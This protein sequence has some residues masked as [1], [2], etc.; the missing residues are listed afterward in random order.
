L[1]RRYWAEFIGTFV[2]VFAPVFTSSV[3]KFHG[4]DGSLLVAAFVSG[5]SVTAMI[6]ALGGISAAH[7]NPAVTLGF[8]VAKRFPWRYVPFYWTAQLAGGIAAAACSYF[9][10]GGGAGAHIPANP[11]GFGANLATEIVLTFILMFVIMSVATDKRVLSS[12]P[13]FAIGATVILDVLIGGPVTGGS[14]NPARSFGP[15]L[16]VSGA[17]PVYWLYLVG[18]I[19]GSMIAALVFEKVRPEIEFAKGAPDGI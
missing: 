5:L 6:V 10:T 14:M 11:N 3:A 8:A 9:I 12:I 2:I 15:A 13:P 1:T 17:L 7:F 18:P 19:I 16:F 4:G